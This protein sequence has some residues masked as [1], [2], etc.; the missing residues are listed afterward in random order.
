MYHLLIDHHWYLPR[1]V[2]AQG[3]ACPWGCLPRSAMW[4]IPSCI[5]CY[6]YAAS[7]PSE[8]QHQCSS[9]YSVTQLHA[10]ILPSPVNR[11]TD[12]CKNITLPQTLFVG[13]NY[14]ISTTIFNWQLKLPLFIF[15]STKGPKSRPLGQG[16]GNKWLK[17][18][19]L[20]PSNLSRFHWFS[21]H[22]I[23]TILQA[24]SRKTI[25]ILYPWRRSCISIWLEIGKIS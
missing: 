16:A 22:P 18:A 7:T 11:V 6:L 14:N 13:G 5:W 9:L 3:G 23:V 15:G 25:S 21:K 24:I 19:T 4:P 10:G 17:A 2:P 1:G 12:R 8:C 20:H